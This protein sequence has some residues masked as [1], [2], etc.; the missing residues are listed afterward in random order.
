MPPHASDGGAVADADGDLLDA[1]SEGIIRI[2]DGRIV[3]ANEP[4]LAVFDRSRDAIIGVDAGT[5]LAG[6]P[7]LEQ[8]ERASTDD[9]EQAFEI[10]DEALGEWLTGKTRVPEEGEEIT[11][12][13]RPITRRKR[14]ESEVEERESTLERLH[15]V[16]ADTSLST[17]EKIEQLLEIGREHLETA[18]GFLTRIR[19]GTQEIR[20]SV[21]DQR[22]IKAGATS[23]L[24]EAYCRHTIDSDEPV[25]VTEASEEGWED[26]PA[27][28]RFGLECYLGATIRV[29]DDTFGTV[30]FADADARDEEF[31]EH[32]RTFAEL[33]TDWIHY[34]LEQR[35]YQ[36]E[37]EEQTAF[38][39]SLLDCLPD[40][41]YAYD[42]TG[43][44]I[45]WNDRLGE[46]TGYEPAEL[47]AMAVT[48]FI[49][50]EDKDDVAKAFEEVLDGQVTSVEA[51]MEGTDGNRIP[52]EFSGAPLRDG[53]DSIQGVVGVGRDISDRLAHQERLAGLLE[54]TRSL[55]QARDREEVGDITVGAAKQLLGF[56]FCSFR[57]FDPERNVLE[58]STVTQSTT[59]LVGELPTYGLDE[60]Y[61]GKA[62]STGKPQIISDLVA[63]EDDVDRPMEPIRSTMIFPVGVHGTLGVGATEVDAFDDTDEQL[64]ALLATSAAA[65]CLRASREREVREAREHTERVLDRVNG[66]VENTIERLVQATTREELERG[67]V[68]ELAAADPYTAAMIGQPDVATDEL[69]PGP[70][71][72]DLPAALAAASFSLA[73]GNDPVSRAYESGTVQ[74]CE[75]VS[76]VDGDPWERMAREANA[77][78]VVALPLTYRDATYG[79]LVV[80]AED[81]SHLDER[82]RMVLE[83]LARA[84]G[85]AIN[86]IERG[87]IL[88]ATEVIELEVAIRDSGLFL[89]RLS[90]D[91]DCT[92][93]TAGIESESS[94]DIRLY[95]STT[96]CEPVGFLEA[97]ADETGVLN[98]SVIV[99][100][101]KSCL[102]EVT[103]AESLLAELADYGAAPETVEAANGTVQVT[104]EL[105]TDAQAREVFDLLEEAY[106]T[107][108]LLGYHE[109]ER[110]IDTHQ[111]YAA[112][113][114]DRLTDR[115]E[116][117]LRTAFLGGF[118]DWP[119]GVDGNELADAMDISRPT[120][121]QHLRAAQRK[122]LEELFQ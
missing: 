83:S 121:H 27:Y 104:V 23:P 60:G 30:C 37:L 22:I 56:E 41:V 87:R 58:P 73:D 67:V 59:D 103:L 61:P 81:A 94:G 101:E 85:N 86:A 69:R 7:L 112:A 6:S 63:A 51:S 119:R 62:F 13:F 55:M 65:A 92:I 8:V 70:T 74:V 109:R 9:S 89:S 118:F 76:R 52:Y 28:Q 64:L 10:Y 12:V 75:D 17:D 19:D 35:R 99:E 95:L 90:A 57:L 3:W 120:Y 21:G 98:H 71:A 45:R 97:L 29:D 43:E 34:L 102:V 26:D 40:P 110:A 91:T 42:E 1:I 68:T 107:V 115:Q 24:S 31:T 114:S 93:A 80:V 100:D 49:A 20:Y 46:V 25:A 72:G 106:E 33:L 78:S 54:T 82:E 113:I 116:T 14:L 47:E 122:V 50:R 105:P 84:T 66:L 38:I 2:E 88:D 32:D 16:A 5:V 79:V 53:T 36:R 117:A 11:L 96:E 48:D 111:E 15:T 4:A 18:T 77:R 44:L 108:D 39:Q